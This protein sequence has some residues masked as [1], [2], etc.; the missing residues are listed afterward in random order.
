[1]A[2]L[3]RKLSQSLKINEL[4]LKLFFSPMLEACLDFSL[5]V[6]CFP[7]SKCFTLFSV[8]LLAL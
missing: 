5:D 8:L 6:L 7:S 3:D 2:E 4:I 1:M